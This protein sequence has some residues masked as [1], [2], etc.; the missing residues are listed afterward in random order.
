MSDTE[1]QLLCLGFTA[2]VLLMHALL[3]IGQ[4]VDASRAAARSLRLSGKWIAT[5]GW[6]ATL[7]R[8][9]RA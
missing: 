8:R 4:A 2:G 6:R 1:I 9:E 7:H 5:D 3:V